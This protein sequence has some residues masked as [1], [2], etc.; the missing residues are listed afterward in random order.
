LNRL[1]RSALYY[2]GLLG[3]A[4]Q[5]RQNSLRILL[6]HRFDIAADGPSQLEWQCQHI[7]RHYA[8]IAMREVAESFA[9]G[10]SLPA[11]AIAVTVDD[12]H[13]DFLQHALPAFSR[14]EIPVTLFVVSDAA[15]GRAWL[16]SDQISHLV[17]QTKHHSIEIDGH[18]IDLKSDRRR[19]ANRITESLKRVPNHE[20]LR[21][22]GELARKLDVEIPPKAPPDYA[23]LDWSDLRTLAR[24]G[25]EIGCHSKTHPILS[26]ME[27]HHDVIAE[28][29]GAKAR[30]EAGLRTPV[31]H[32]AY[33]NGTWNDFN[34]EITAAVKSGG[35]LCA[36]T[37]ESGLNQKSSDPFALLRLGMEPSFSKKRF[38]ELLA[39][40]RK[41]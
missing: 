39:G 25:I 4:R 26:Q 37:A 16:W 15:D 1:T 40:V 8:P 30:I 18:A 31:L 22:R 29:G 19:A 35:F 28:I 27:D 38:S 11:N 9:L 17:A 5:F 21:M 6:Y 41:Y 36:V 24:Q 34:P 33:P 23:L 12:G 13:R 14:Y 2:S 7:R 32:F 20:R 10:R 3:A